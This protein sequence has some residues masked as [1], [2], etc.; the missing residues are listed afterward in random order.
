M[1]AVAFLILR[2][3]RGREDPAVVWGPDRPGKDRAA[4]EPASVAVSPD[5][6]SGPEID[7][8]TSDSDAPPADRPP[9]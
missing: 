1:G 2:R 8:T 7:S 6:P 5:A 9:G 3:N 4:P